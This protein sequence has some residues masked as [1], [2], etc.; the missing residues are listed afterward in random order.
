MKHSSVTCETL[1]ALNLIHL[2]H[3]SAVLR[4]S[5]YFHEKSWFYIDLNGPSDT[6]GALFQ[7][8]PDERDILMNIEQTTWEGLKAVEL[9][10][11]RLRLVAVYEFG[12]RISFL[13]KP[14]GENLLLWAPGKYFR[15]TWELRG[16]HRVWVSR[17]LAD[18]CEETYLQDDGECE[19]ELTETGFTLTAPTD[20]F[21]ETQ[22]SLSVKIRS[23]NS[24]AVDNA[25]TN[26]GEMLYSGGIWALTCTLPREQ[27][28]YSIPLG[29][30][31][32]WDL[33]K[34]VMFRRWG[35]HDGGYDD[36]QFSFKEDMMLIRPEG[37]EN[38]RMIW[39]DKG[40]M[41]MIDPDLD[42]T[43][44]KKTDSSPEGR[45]P[46]G[47]NTAAYIGPENFM[48]E[49]ETMGA[50]KTVKPGESIHNIETWVLA[51]AVGLESAGDLIGLF[52]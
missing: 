26:T 9:T 11:D 32:E 38:K 15:N 13:G 22:R 47:T 37:R 6:M 14:G 36:S 27:T 50:E 20:T 42:I 16:G 2:S 5:G 52:D 51:D 49:M 45:Y 24:L 30:G 8:W 35:G 34:V 25:L 10:T 18:E 12:P 33:C 23:D 3:I 4:F 40:I 1:S 31:N 21:N 44:A 39:A 41:A 43:F 29:D 28:V 46:Q 7:A 17:P 19:V 48:V